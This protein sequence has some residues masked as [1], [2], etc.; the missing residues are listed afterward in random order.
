RAKNNIDWTAWSKVYHS[1]NANLSSVNWAT[2]DLTVSGLAQFEDTVKANGD[3]RFDII[4]NE[5]S[6]RIH[7]TGLTDNHS[8]FVEE[9]ADGE[10]TNLVIF[11]EDNGADGTIIR[12][13]STSQATPIDIANFSNT[14]VIFNPALF[15]ENLNL[16]LTKGSN[17]DLN[18]TTN[19]GWTAIGARNENY[20]HFHTDRPSFYFDKSIYLNGNLINYTSGTGRYI[21]KF[22]YYKTRSFSSRVKY[23]LWDDFIGIGYVSDADF[24]TTL[25][26]GHLSGGGMTFQTKSSNRGFWW[27]NADQN[28]DGQGAM[29]LTTDGRL[30]VGND[31]TVVDGAEFGGDIR[32]NTSTSGNFW[33][34]AISTAGKSN[35]SGFW[36]NSD[37]V[38][39]YLR[40]S[41]GN[42]NVTLR[43]DGNSQLTHGLTLGGDLSVSGVCTFSKTL[44]ASLGENYAIAELENDE[45]GFRLLANYDGYDW[46]QT[47][48][49]MK[50]SGWSGETLDELNIRATK[51]IFSGAADFGGT[52]KAPEIQ[53][54]NSSLKLTKNSSNRLVITTPNGYTDIGA[55]NEAWSHFYTDRPGFY[56]D[57]YIA[58]NGNILNYNNQSGRH[59]GDFDIYSA[60]AANER[61]KFRLWGY[62]TS[63]YGIGMTSGVSYG[64]IGGAGSQYA[65]IFQM[66]ATSN[67]GFWWGKN[68]D[69]MTTQGAMSLTTDG[70]LYVGNDLTV[71]NGAEFGSTIKSNG[72][73]RFD[74]IKNESS[75]RIHWT[76]LTDNH[77]IFVEETA[78]V[79]S[80][81]LVIFNE[82]NGADG[83]II[84]NRASSQ[85]IDVAKFVSSGVTIK[86]SLKVEGSSSNTI[87]EVISS[88]A[89]ESELRLR[90]SSQGS[91]R[92]YVGQSMSHGGGIEYNGDTNPDTNSGAGSDYF[93]LYRRSNSVSTWTARN[94][95]NSDN[96]EFKGDVVAYSSSDKR[97]KKNIKTI[98]NPLEK[99]K[100]I[101]GYSF[102]WEANQEAYQGQDIGVIAQEIEDIFPIPNVVCTKEDGYKAVKYEKL[103]AL[104]IESVKELSAQ[105]EQLNNRITALENE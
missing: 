14:G 87:I 11:N 80:T 19:H 44:K 95:H 30:Y 58:V 92:V 16:K 32:I 45:G 74:I 13:K 98:E 9:T 17:N 65:M 79:E 99:V 85:S 33:P 59:V 64:H 4:K 78:N 50:L 73:I 21:G 31:L 93:A 7:W 94:L 105:N 86:P 47:Q 82:D 8:I 101:G 70:K 67:R 97:F 22:D 25:N 20:S 28:L 84:R 75:K 37:S 103:I 100:K 81:N 29:S 51:S 41:E 10:S 96:W 15:I 36:T 54:N 104:L 72:D 2:R 90:G 12:N 3:I 68:S 83:T 102:E 46:Y 91:G 26:F 69:N 6:K 77:S 24:A 42:L 53:I 56:F 57:K 52:I 55:G 49:N 76:G 48:Q 63:S 23:G 38:A 61:T 40:D 66:D 18:I 71:V 89:Y 1:N 27:G 5:D 35:N 43:S 88:D 34:L 39:L 60:K 62:E